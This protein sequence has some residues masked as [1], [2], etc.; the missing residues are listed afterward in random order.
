MKDIYIL[1]NTLENVCPAAAV[2]HYKVFS[3][4]IQHVSS[5]KYVTTNNNI[6]HPLFFNS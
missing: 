2:I 4:N 6:C 1:Q 3:P 5:L